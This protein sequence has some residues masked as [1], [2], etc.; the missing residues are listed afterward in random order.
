MSKVCQKWSQEQMQELEKNGKLQFGSQK[1]KVG[2]KMVVTF[3][4][5]QKDCLVVSTNSKLDANYK[6]SGYAG[7][8]PPIR[9][10]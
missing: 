2:H 9:N 3:R 1:Y 8:I 6:S 7:K 10:M 5:E 4:V